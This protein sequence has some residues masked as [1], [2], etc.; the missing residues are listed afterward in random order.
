[1]IAKERD[2]QIVEEKL[3]VSK[4]KKKKSDCKFYKDAYGE[5]WVF[6]KFFYHVRILELFWT[7]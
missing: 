3:R 7:W 1:M 2:Q 4:K 5:M 6:L